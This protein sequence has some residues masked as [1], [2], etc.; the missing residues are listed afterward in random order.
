WNSA[1]EVLIFNASTVSEKTLNSWFGTYKCRVSNNYQ[2]VNVEFTIS[3]KGIV[4]PKVAETGFE[5]WWIA[6]IVAVL[7]IIIIILIIFCCIKRNYPGE[8]YQL[9]KT[10]LKHHLNPKEELLNQSFPEV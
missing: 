3:K 4:A 7:L 9:E 5:L 10:E 6:I 2:E 1:T 8:T